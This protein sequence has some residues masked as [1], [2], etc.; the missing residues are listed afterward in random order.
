[1]CESWASSRL[2][3][4]IFP[5]LWIEENVCT[6]SV[7]LQTADRLLVCWQWKPTEYLASMLLQAGLESGDSSDMSG[8]VAESL[9]L[10]KH[11]EEIPSQIASNRDFFFPTSQ[12][13]LCHTEWV[14][15]LWFSI[16]GW[17]TDGS[18][19]LT[20]QHAAVVNVQSLS[21]N[22]VSN[23][24][25]FPGEKCRSFLYVA[26]SNERGKNMMHTPKSPNNTEACGD[27]VL[28]PWC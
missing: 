21:A 12:L 2:T 20:Y 10:H 25:S 24:S 19:C 8:E 16:S 6:V 17:R 3:S 18:P 28:S 7:C 11:R 13:S 14:N 9:L 5:Q 22:E 15:Y 1:M 23:F 27:T 26:P 4:C